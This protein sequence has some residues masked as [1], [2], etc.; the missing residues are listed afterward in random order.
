MRSSR[1]GNEVMRP[2]MRPSEEPF[3]E[4]GQRKLTCQ[5]SYNT[6]IYEQEASYLEIGVLGQVIKL[7]QPDK[8]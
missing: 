6:Y 4:F 5:E 1:V 2:K 8:I 3:C 7:K